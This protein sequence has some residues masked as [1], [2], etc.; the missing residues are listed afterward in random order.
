MST[1]NDKSLELHTKV[2]ENA[3]MICNEIWKDA[4]FDFK[5]GREQCIEKY[6]MASYVALALNPNKV[7]TLM[8]N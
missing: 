7:K 5:H 6:Y 8:K 3:K 4:K 2:M 1:E